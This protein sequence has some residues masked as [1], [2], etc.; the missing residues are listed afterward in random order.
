MGRLK[1]HRPVSEEGTRSLEH[2]QRRPPRSPLS[3]PTPPQ[4]PTLNSPQN[5]L[6][7]TL[8]LKSPGSGP[9]EEEFEHDVPERLGPLRFVKLANTPLPG[10]RRV[11]LRP[12]HVSGPGA[13]EDGPSRAT[14]GCQGEGVLSCPRQRMGSGVRC[15]PGELRTKVGGRTEK[16]GPPGRKLTTDNSCGLWRMIYLQNMRFRR[17][18]LDFEWTQKAGAWSVSSNVVYTLLSSWKNRRRIL[19][20]SS[21]AREYLAGQCGGL[22]SN[23][24]YIPPFPETVPCVSGFHPPGWNSSQ[25][26]PREKQYLAAP[27][28]HAEWTPMGNCFPWS[29]SE[30]CP[31]LQPSQPP[32][33]DPT[34]LPALN[35]SPL[36]W[37]LAKSWVRIQIFQLHQLQY[38]LLNTSSAGR[39]HRCGHHEVPPRTA[40]CLQVSDAPTSAT[41]WKS[42]PGTDP[43]HLNGVYL[44]RA[45]NVKI[46]HLNPLILCFGFFL[47]GPH[48]SVPA[49]STGGGGH[50]HLLPPAMAQLTYCSLF[51]PTICRT[52]AAGNP[53]L[54]TPTIPYGSGTLRP[55]FPVSF[56]PRI[57]LPFL[58]MCSSH[59]TAQ[60]GG[61]Q[62]GQVPLG[63][64]KEKYFLRTKAKA[65]LNQFQT[66][67]ANLERE[68]TARNEQLDLPYEYLKPSLTENTSSLS[69][70][71]APP[72]GRPQISL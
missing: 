45:L 27:P 12:H 50:V 11:F 42:T 26:D 66:D 5:G 55:G 13:G 69:D 37:L 3:V 68:I 23:D 39:G 1:S 2:C 70:S 41:L 61:H 6:P 9:T 46:P 25:C 56:H 17:K 54:T 32:A 51:L 44:I 53:V 22:N 4:T 52:R 28:R 35:P 18:R 48:L 40:P 72:P 33:P 24:G 7:R 15:E 20:T 43:T 34:T 19:I 64:H 14:A 49:V 57:N 59:A 60:H 16:A 29:S 47:K 63:H 31:N 58:T 10:G 62:Q 36:A 67:L 38:H 71:K 65:A 8:P 21:G 30:T